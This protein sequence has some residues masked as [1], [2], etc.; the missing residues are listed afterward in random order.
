MIKKVLK[1]IGIVILCIG[2]IALLFIKFWPSLGG[3]VNKEDE[4]NYKARNSLYK[5]G[6]FHGNPEIQLMTGQKSEYK[7]EEKVPKGEIPIHKLKKIEKAKM[8]ELKWTWFGHS[9]SLLQ[10]E[11]KNVLTDPVFSNY[12]SPVPFIG[13]K[14]F[15]KLPIDIENMPNIDV[16]A[17][18]HDHYDHLDYQTIKQID[19]KVKEYCVPLGIEKHLLRWGV[20]EKKIHVMNWWDEVKV[21]GLTIT[22]TPGRHFTGRVPWRNNTTLWS[23][24]NIN[25]WHIFY[26]YR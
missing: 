10:I 20:N 12:S 16:L 7:N 21:D 3:N 5:K 13:P 15:S 17:I 11:G 25:I 9:S 19:E 6:I 8:D 23:G 1:I 2:V 22:S 4:K 24:K 18:S 14:R 26:I